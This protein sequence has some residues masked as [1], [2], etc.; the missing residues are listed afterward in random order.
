MMSAVINLTGLKFS[1]LTVVTRAENRGSRSAWN[2][3]CECGL[4][5]IALAQ[6]LKSGKTASCG[7]LNTDV[8]NGNRNRSSNADKRGIPVCECLGPRSRGQNYRMCDKHQGL[9]TRFKLSPDD[10]D[11]KYQEQMGLCGI[12][13]EPM[14]LPEARVDH[15]HRTGQVRSL[16]HHGCNTHLGH[17]E[18]AM[19]SSHPKTQMRATYLAKHAVVVNEAAE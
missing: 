2:C 4:E 6:S 9:W 18:L 1:R 7:C 8:R 15:N 10:M 17:Y 5:T 13:N 16:A 19:D 14:T 12:C 3:V 11:R